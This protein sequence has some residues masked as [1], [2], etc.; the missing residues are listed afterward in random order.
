MVPRET[1]IT[2]ACGNKKDMARIDSVDQETKRKLDLLKMLLS[3][4][5]GSATYD[6]AIQYAL[7]A[8]DVP[9]DR[10]RDQ[11]SQMDI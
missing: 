6:D 2:Q 1:I 7:T 11:L 4:E 8:E 10:V 5:D 9:M 3:G